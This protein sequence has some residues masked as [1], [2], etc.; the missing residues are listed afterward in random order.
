MGWYLEFSGEPAVESLQ[1]HYVAYRA[2]VRAKVSCIQAA[3]G[4]ATAAAGAAAYA[5]LALRHLRAGEVTLLLV[6]GA[7][8]TGKTTLSCGIAC[9]R[10][11]VVL[12]SDEIRNQIFDAGGDRYSPG[13][14]LAVYTELLARARRAVERGVSVVADATWGDTVVRGLAAEVAVATSSRLVEMECHAPLEVSAA[15]AQRRLATR[16]DGS[17][18]DARI[19]RQLAATRERWPSAIAVDTA[20]TPRTSLEQALMALEHAT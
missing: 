18:A 5:Q 19:A 7:P 16:K 4:S 9:S 8:G 15:R 3:Q 11:W 6:G 14:K 13:A 17:E 10:G 20:V 2:F 1:H 12:S